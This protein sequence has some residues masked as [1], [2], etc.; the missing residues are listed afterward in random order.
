MPAESPA[1]SEVLDSAIAL[2]LSSETSPSSLPE[3]SVDV[4]PTTYNA[5]KIQPRH[6]C[7]L[8]EMTVLTLSVMFIDVMLVPALPMIIAR[9]L[10]DDQ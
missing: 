1:P 2:P 10:R 9:L 6:I 8:L 5:T 4:P 3:K 7:L